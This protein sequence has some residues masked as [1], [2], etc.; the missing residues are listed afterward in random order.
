MLYTRV[1]LWNQPNG[2]IV[3]STSD[4]VILNPS[5]EDKEEDFTTMSDGHTWSFVCSRYLIATLR[6]HALYSCFTLCLEVS[7]FVVGG[8]L[9]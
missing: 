6:G 2:R 7:G 5:E 3:G 9:H 1:D 8:S 4:I